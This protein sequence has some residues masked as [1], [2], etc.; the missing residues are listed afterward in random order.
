MPENIIIIGGGAAG[1]FAAIR[2]KERYP[3]AA[4]TILEK[5]QKVLAKVKI[6]GGGRCNVTHACFVP[7]DLVQYYPRGRKELLAPFKIFNPTQTVEWF[8]QRGVKL[9]AEADGRMFP[10][11]NDSQTIVDCLY[12]TARNLGVIVRLGEGVTAIRQNP[13]TQFSLST[14][15]N[16]YTADRLIITAG[17]S[18]Q[19]WAILA[20]LGHTIVSPVPSLFT[21]TV[22][23]TRITDLAG[24]AVADA[25]V[26]I[27]AAKLSERGIILVTHWGFSAPAVLRLSAWGARALNDLNY[28]FE[29]KINFAP[30][31]T[32][33]T[34]KLFL[35]EHKTA[36]P[37]KQIAATALLDLPNRLWKSLVAAALIPDALT[38]ADISKKQIQAFAEQLTMATFQVTGKSTFKEEFVTAG[39]LHLKEVN[40][41]TMESK[42]IA[43]L[44]FAGEVL[45]IDAITGGF[46]FQAAWTTAWIA[47]ENS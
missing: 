27:P 15:Y 46:N 33:E 21:F 16:I 4:V 22:K 38:W 7:E 40:F 23:D 18:P 25:L 12:H 8:R 5:Q 3:S 2:V 14:P 39:G 42:K 6:S 43:N 17:S 28:N 24:V 45:D 41:K 31:H 44:F 13:D 9:K 10:V 11:S 37:K 35:M 29:L 36:Y 30:S 1:F 19:I 20:E 47:A 26:Q 34:A 32:V